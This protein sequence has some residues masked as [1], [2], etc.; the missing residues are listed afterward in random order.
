LSAFSRPDVEQKLRERALAAPPLLLTGPPGAG[1]TTLLRGLAAQLSAQGA[2]PVYLDL[3][4]ACSTP[5]RFVVAALRAIPAEGLGRRLPLATEIHRLAG[6]GRL[7]GAEAVTALFRLWASLDEAEGRPVVLL[8]DEA[9]EIRSLAYFPGL[10][11]VHDPFAAALAAR[12][13][14]TVLASSFPSAARKLWTV[15]TLAARPLNAADL[16]GVPQAGDIVRGSFGWPRYAAILIDAVERD[17][18]SV[19]AAW[20]REMALGG[21]LETACRQTYESLL[22]RSRGY[23]ICKAALGVIAHEEGLNLTA[24]V[25]RLGRT[26]GAVRDYLQWLVGVDAIRMVKKK[27]VYVDG[28]LRHWVRLHARGV[29]P[30]TAELDAAARELLSGEALKS[31]PDLPAPAPTP[32]PQPMNPD[33]S[34]PARRDSLIEID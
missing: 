17:G 32:V 18:G 19:G 24:L 20:S 31:A 23:G 13:R 34:S 6:S 33:P 15:E 8:L 5:E 14:G 2:V 4:G 1:K 27:Y 28:L 7:H 30:A 10:R 11:H 25:P 16:V 21:R 26:P 9:T 12:R 29:V 22:L 3:M